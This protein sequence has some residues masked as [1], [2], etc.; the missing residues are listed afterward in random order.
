MR[1]WKDTAG[2]KA[3]ALDVDN[4]YPV[5]STT[6]SSKHHQETYPSAPSA[7]LDRLLSTS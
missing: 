6:Q 4:L 7:E 2:A 5:P 3:F 1:G